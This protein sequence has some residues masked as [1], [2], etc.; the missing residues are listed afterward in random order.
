MKNVGGFRRI[1]RCFDLKYGLNLVS[2]S[3]NLN[4]VVQASLFRTPLFC[5]TN[6][7]RITHYSQ[8]K[9][10]PVFPAENIATVA[11]D[12]CLFCDRIVPRYWQTEALV[13]NF[14]TAIKVYVS[15]YTN[16]RENAPD[17][18]FQRERGL[19]HQKNFHRQTSPCRKPDQNIRPLRERERE[20][21]FQ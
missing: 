21:V 3:L 9:E 13:L 16:F 8:R 10:N 20:C 1:F 2:E 7:Q 4:V 17:K 11:R 15:N 19:F 6:G 14:G 5:V 12:N 18:T